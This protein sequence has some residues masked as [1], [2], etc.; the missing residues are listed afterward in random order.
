MKQDEIQNSNTRRV[1][2]SYNL[3]FEN[4]ETI[5]TRKDKPIINP[6]RWFTRKPGNDPN[7]E[8]IAIYMKRVH[9]EEREFLKNIIQKFIGEIEQEIENDNFLSQQMTISYNQLNLRHQSNKK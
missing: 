2:Q 6:A 4:F 9:S 1:T 7:D 8:N 5:S 3:D